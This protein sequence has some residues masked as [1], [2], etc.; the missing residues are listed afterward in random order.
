[1]GGGI[2]SLFSES[3]TSGKTEKTTAEEEMFDEEK[4]ILQ[5]QT[6]EDD[7]SHLKIVMAH[8]HIQ[9][10]FRRH[11]EGKGKLLY[12]K[13][14][15]DL[16]VQRERLLKTVHSSECMLA[17]DIELPDI[18]SLDV[19]SFDIHIALNRCLHPLLKLKQTRQKYIRIDILVELFICCE[20]RLLMF[21]FDE[22]HDY[23]HSTSYQSWMKQHPVSSEAANNELPLPATPKHLHYSKNIPSA[24]ELCH[25]YTKSIMSV[26]SF[27]D[28]LEG[29]GG[30]AENNNNEV[31]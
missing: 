24:T 13:T 7:I 1:M 29:V 19:Q 14:F 11:I 30:D 10:E 15:Q 25:D 3:P 26:H 27:H 2:S 31:Y 20:E 22:F 16:Q 5:N 9:K 21:I 28:S 18:S 12:L 4:M 8:T 17:G 23:I 6:T